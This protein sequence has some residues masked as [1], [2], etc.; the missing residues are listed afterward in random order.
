MIRLMYIVHRVWRDFVPLYKKF[1]LYPVVGTMLGRYLGG[2][3][4]RSRIFITPDKPT[5]EI[6]ATFYFRILS[7]PLEKSTH[8]HCTSFLNSVHTRKDRIFPV[9]PIGMK[10]RKIVFVYSI[11]YMEI[12]HKTFISVH[13]YDAFLSIQ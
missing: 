13:K 8:V 5:S 1:C 10:N 7:K 9:I 6:F 4:L 3:I 2:I 11:T 12:E